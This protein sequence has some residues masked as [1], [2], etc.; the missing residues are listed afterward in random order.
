MWRSWADLEAWAQDDM[1]IKVYWFHEHLR[2]RI[3]HTLRERLDTQQMLGA[4]FFQG[5]KPDHFY[6][7]HFLFSVQT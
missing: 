6:Y 7:C 1:V 3:S 4:D 2:T 5:C